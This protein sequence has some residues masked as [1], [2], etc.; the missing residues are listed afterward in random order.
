MKLDFIKNYYPVW[1]RQVK[2]YLRGEREVFEVEIPELEGTSFQ[3]AVWRAMLEIPYGQ[4]RSYG[5][6]AAEVGRPRAYRAVANACGKNPLPIIIP[7]H[8]V[9]ASKG[10]GGFSLGIDLKKRLLAIE[11][12]KLG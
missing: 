6:L 7:C 9:V 3:R 2:E 4:T 12:V 8:R 1:Q 5:Q 10:L 11:G